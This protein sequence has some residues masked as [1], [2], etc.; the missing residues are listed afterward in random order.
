MAR[1]VITAAKLHALLE[2]EFLEARAS[3]C[4][5]LCH[6]PMP[7][8]RQPAEAGSPNWF[9]GTPL[10]CPRYCHKLILRAVVKYS[11][12]YDVEPPGTART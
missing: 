4:A 9:I 7:L 6:V 1:E 12:I 3:E 5:S 8:F 2:R 10:H 11:A